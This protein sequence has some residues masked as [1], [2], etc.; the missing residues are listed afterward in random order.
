MEDGGGADARGPLPWRACSAPPACWPSRSS[1][2]PRGAWTTAS[3]AA[4][5]RVA[6]THGPPTPAHE[7]GRSRDPQPRPPHR[8]ATRP[9]SP[10]PHM[11]AGTPRPALPTGPAARRA[12]C[13]TEGRR[14]PVHSESVPV[15]PCRVRRVC[16]PEGRARHRRVPRGV[17]G[18]MHPADRTGTPPGA[19]S[20]AR[21]VSCPRAALD[22]A[23]GGPAARRSGGPL[24]GSS[25]VPRPGGRR[26][27]GPSPAGSVPAPRP[28]PPRSAPR[29]S[30]PRRPT[31]VS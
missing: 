12:V 30:P 3:V 10:R 7:P 17:R 6:P 18:R 20:R 27:P 9:G 1:R 26:R 22:A 4:D 21:R 28:A 8:P 23:P 19:S 11:P 29:L 5:P 24:P 2:P 13:P 15:D 25:G 31:E 14:E 16:A